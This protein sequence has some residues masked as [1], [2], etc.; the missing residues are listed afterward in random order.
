MSKPA[1]ADYGVDAPVA[2]RNMLIV[3]ALGMIALITRVA[4]V[5]G[6]ES[7]FAMLGRPLISAGLA[8]GAM[9]G[10]MIVS[11]RQPPRMTS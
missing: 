11:V 1:R 7:S 10:W 8:C 6:R 3:C 9:A 5:W 4:G 2:I